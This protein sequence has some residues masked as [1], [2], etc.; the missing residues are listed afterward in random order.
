[1]KKQLEIY[2][3]MHM[4]SHVKTNMIALLLVFAVAFSCNSDKG[5]NE[6]MDTIVAGYLQVKDALVQTNAEAAGEAAKTLASLA[7]DLEGDG[8]SDINKVANELAKQ[9]DVRRQREQF[10][11]L[12]E[13][14]YSLVKETGSSGASLY[15]QY[16]PMAFDNAGAYWL[17]GEKVLFSFFFYRFSFFFFD[18]SARVY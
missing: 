10:Q 4:K 7:G 17:A 16:C 13:T 11:Q 1:M 15:R 18:L 3:F 2:I 6:Q 9:T 12:S 8:W 5:Q 14:M